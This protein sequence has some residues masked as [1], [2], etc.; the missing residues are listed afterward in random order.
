ME[1]F[2]GKDVIVNFLPNDL[3]FMLEVFTFQAMWDNIQRL[4]KNCSA[5]FLDFNR[6]QVS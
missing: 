1:R 5:Y 6:L 2:S 4:E 3:D